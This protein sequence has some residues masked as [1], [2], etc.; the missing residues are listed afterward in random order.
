MN[1]PE[2]FIRRPVMTTLI[3]LAILIFGGMAYRLLPVSDLPNVDYPTLSVYANLPGASPETMASSVATPLERQFSTINGLD[4]MTS[5]SSLGS[6]RITLQ[7]RLDRDLDAAAQDVQAAISQ[8]THDLPSDM[9]SPP[10]FRKSNP[11]DQPILYLT[12]SSPVLPLSTVDDYAEVFIGQRLSMVNGVAE[13]SVYGS[14]KYAVRI[15][16]DP[17]QLTSRGIGVDEVAGAVRQGN[18]NMPTGTLDGAHQAFTVEANGQLTSAKDYGPLIVAWRNGAAVRV[19]DLGRA[20]DSVENDKSASWLNN[21]RAVILSIQRQPGTNTVEVVDAILALLPALKAQLP[22]PVNLG[23]L[24]DKSQSIRASVHEVKFTLLLAMGLVVLVIFLFLRNLR[25]TIIPSLSL[26][27]SVVGT[28]A[29]MY[30]LGFSID[31]LSMVA[32]ILSVGFVVDDAIVMLENIVRHVER[33]EPPYQAALRGSGEIGFTILSMTLSLVAVFIPVLFMGGIIGRLLNEFAVTIS[34]SILMSGFVSL[35]L[36]PMLC[37][38]FLRPPQKRHSHIFNVSELFFR[39]M[40][41]VY[42]WTLRQT[43]RFH[44]LTM[45]VFVATI[46]LTAHLFQAIPKGF[47]PSEDTGQLS[48]TTEGAQGIS[49]EA[50]KQHQQAVAQVMAADPN[51]DAFM[52]SVGSSS[53]G[54]NTGRLFIHLKP[55]AERALSADAV[56]QALRPKLGAIPGISTYLQNPPSISFGGRM[57][58]SQYQYTLQSPDNAELDE[59]APLLVAKIR[60]IPGILDVTSDLQITNPQVNV[61]IDRDKAASLGVS[62]QQ[63]EDALYTAYGSRQVSTIF[64]PTDTY[65]VILELAPQ[66]QSD[67]D[68]LSMLYVRTP[69]GDLAPLSTMTKITR[70][71][72]PLSIN[73]QGQL[74]AVTISFNLDPKMALGDAVNAVSKAAAETLPGS[75][76]TSFQGTAQAFTSSLTGLGLL[77]IMAV[78]VIYIVLGILY[79]SFIHPLT[80]LSGLP[81]AGAGALLALRLFD[82]PLDLY[83]FVGVIMLLGIVKK[84]AIMMIDFALDAQRREGLSPS[85]AILQGALIR[86]RP[87]MMTTMAALMGTLPIAIGVGTGSQ[88]RQPLGIAVVGGLVVSQLLTLYITPVF[89]TYM[90]G[91]RRLFRRRQAPAPT[92][93]PAPAEAVVESV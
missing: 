76:S 47:L 7:F 5:S 49:Y 56:I 65:K 59:Y 35:T 82:K 8:A 15:E 37:S 57:A 86:F 92:S 24:Y 77:L 43:M 60:Q 89:Y 39:G 19:S 50:L 2:L 90:E 18:V 31:N 34:V 46:F 78:L 16:L 52:S 4:S 1:I 38:R 3:M 28:F 32:L 73:H 66:Y 93:A 53:G 61:D 6:T 45:A 40:L 62:V 26:P 20:F 64:A 87:I 10:Y 14:Q 88:A 91:L 36:T 74:P 75:I 44:P 9:P 55:R 58:K 13:V 72:G 23:I 33:G 84:N 29:V 70:N 68:A 63:I 11:A 25:A 17:R 42:E 51:I 81:A 12:L 85:Q 69:R 30:L 21:Q 80:I 54:G 41:A 48:G 83:G 27:M 71:V 67:P 22:A 79:E